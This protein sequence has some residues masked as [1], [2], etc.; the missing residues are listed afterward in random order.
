MA[1]MVTAVT[2]K[3]AADIAEIA[4]SYVTAVAKTSDVSIDEVTLLESKGIWEIGGCH[5]STPFTRSRRFQLQLNTDG[6][7]TLFVSQPGSSLAPF[8]AG[9]SIIVGSLIFLIWVL[10]LA[11]L[12]K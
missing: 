7:V 2:S 5:R 6:A 12:D 10:Y 4:R 9:I 11:S 1:A 8:V 3:S